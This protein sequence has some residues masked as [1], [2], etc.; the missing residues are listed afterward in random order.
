MVAAGHGGAALRAL[1]GGSAKGAPQGGRKGV[2]EA[3]AVAVASRRMTNDD[4]RR[5]GAA[6]H[7]IRVRTSTRALNVH[8][9]I[10]TKS[11][12]KDATPGR[13][14]RRTIAHRFKELRRVQLKRARI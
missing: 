13:L 11:E 7:A 12:R 9:N 5:T 14:R 10:R 6:G 1:D 8:K 3:G 2:R 4:G